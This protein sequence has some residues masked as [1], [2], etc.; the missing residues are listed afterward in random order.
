MVKLAAF[1]ASATVA[2]SVLFAA[3]ALHAAAKRQAT[4]KLVTAWCWLDM[5]VLDLVDVGL[6]C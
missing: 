1:S 6:V 3:F 4:S 2:C 5:L